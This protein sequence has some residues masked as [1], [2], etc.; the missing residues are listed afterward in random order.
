MK[1]F[2]FDKDSAHGPHTKITYFLFDRIF[3][4]NSFVFVFFLNIFYSKISKTQLPHS[5]FFSALVQGKHRLMGNGDTEGLSSAKLTV[6]F[7]H[8]QQRAFLRGDSYRI[9]VKLEKK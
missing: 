7:Q 2:S 4:L 5:L 6:I 3:P 9:R 1:K 8:V